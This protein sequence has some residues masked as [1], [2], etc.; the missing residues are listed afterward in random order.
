M[1]NLDTG[2]ALVVD[3]GSG[4]GEAC[5]VA[6]AMTLL[7]SAAARWITGATIPVDGGMRL[8]GHPPRLHTNKRNQEN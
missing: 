2:L 4:I 8:R 1:A 3:G 7:V 5:D 6:D